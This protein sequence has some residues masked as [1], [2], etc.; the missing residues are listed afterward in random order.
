MSTSL[1]QAALAFAGGMAPALMVVLFPVRRWA[2]HREALADALAAEADYARRLRED[3]AAPFDP[4]PFVRARAAATPPGPLRS[5]YR[6]TQLHGPRSLVERLRPVLAGLA[7]PALTP[8]AD[9]ERARALLATAATVLDAAAPSSFPR[10]PRRHSAV[11]RPT[12]RSPLPP[13]TPQSDSA[14][15]CAS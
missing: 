14:C 5:R 3:P 2:P 10:A 9:E 1:G 12:S 6:P 4:K 13:R 7:H 11:R 8:A 15:S